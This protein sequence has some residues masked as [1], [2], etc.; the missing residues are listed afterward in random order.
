M[1]KTWLIPVLLF[2]VGFAAIWGFV[3]VLLAVLSGWSVLAETYRGQLATVTASERMASAR[4][5]R[6]G[7]PVNFN[8]CLHVSVGDEG[9]E[10]AVFKLFALRAPP[11]LIPWSHVADGRSD[12]Q[13]GLFDRFTFRPATADVKVTL[14]GR[15]ARLLRDETARRGHLASPAA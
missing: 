9:V 7:I 10:L 5:S 13:F 14:V 12:R 8:H 15:A 1:D 4:M 6:F 2:P 3:A 11:L